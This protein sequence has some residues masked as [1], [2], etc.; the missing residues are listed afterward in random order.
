VF[1]VRVLGGEYRGELE[2]NVNMFD[3]KFWGREYRE[4]RILSNIVFFLEYLEGNVGR[5]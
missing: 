4:S 1:D 2:L 3:V 5:K